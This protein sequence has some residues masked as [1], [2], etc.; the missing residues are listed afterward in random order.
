MQTIVINMKTK[1]GKLVRRE[2]D[3]SNFARHE[4]GT[5]VVETEPRKQRAILQDWIDTRGN[6]QH[7]TVL[8]LI[9]WFIT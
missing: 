6:V 7:E 9:D 4:G 1:Q 5:A 2:I 8:Q 3:I